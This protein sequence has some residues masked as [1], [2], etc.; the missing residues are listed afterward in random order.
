MRR[1]ACAQFL[2]AGTRMLGGEAVKVVV[3]TG[4]VRTDRVGAGDA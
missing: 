1:I 3:G 4:R 2:L